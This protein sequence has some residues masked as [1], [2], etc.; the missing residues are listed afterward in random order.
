MKTKDL[1]AMSLPDLEKQLK[2]SRTE[3]FNLRF[4]MAT[5]QLENH[6]QIRH[7]RRTLAQILTEMIEKQFQAASQPPAPVAEPEPEPQPAAS[8]KPSRRRKK[9]EA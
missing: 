1:H 2:T 7:V 4:Q 9:E 8:A 3:L 6:R 5:G